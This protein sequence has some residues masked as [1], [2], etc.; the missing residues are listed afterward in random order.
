M[1]W[2]KALGSCQYESPG[3]GLL[4]VHSALEEAFV[5]TMVGDSYDADVYWIGAHVDP[6]TLAWKWSNDSLP[7]DHTAWAEGQ[8]WPNNQVCMRK[9]SERHLGRRD[10]TFV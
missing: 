5:A 6:E 9:G 7:F 1:L 10:V 8:P 2:D 4:S 3:Y